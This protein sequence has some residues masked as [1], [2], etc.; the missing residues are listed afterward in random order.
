MQ[1]EYDKLQAE[2]NSLV[3]RARVAD[4]P[5]ERTQLLAQMRDALAKIREFTA[6][7]YAGADKRPSPNP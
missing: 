2:F 5:T 7:V 3:E 4:D 6:R 1:K